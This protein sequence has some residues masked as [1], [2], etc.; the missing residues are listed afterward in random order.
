M[1]SGDITRWRDN[2]FFPT[3]DLLH[4]VGFFRQEY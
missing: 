4:V 2:E 1:K 3:N